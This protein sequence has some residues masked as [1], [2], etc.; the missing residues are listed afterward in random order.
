MTVLFDLDHSK[1]E[2]SSSS[3]C[4]IGYQ[5]A[6]RDAWHQ[7]LQHIER[8]S[9]IIEQNLEDGQFMEY[10]NRRCVRHLLV[11][12]R[13]PFANINFTL[14]HSNPSLEFLTLDGIHVSHL[15]CHDRDPFHSLGSIRLDGGC[16]TRNTFNRLLN[17]S[18]VLHTLDICRCML[19]LMLSWSCVTWTEEN[20]CAGSNIHLS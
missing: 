8:F 7:R 9:L 12:A 10:V 18:P 20:F 19:M 6:R 16:M 5:S 1:L 3:Y 11:S 2:G 14:P 15:F 17:L 13:P 4:C